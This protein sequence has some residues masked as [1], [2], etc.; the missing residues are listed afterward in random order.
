MPRSL[1]HHQPLCT[2]TRQDVYQ[3]LSLL[4]S[5]CTNDTEPVVD[6][7]NAIRKARRVVCWP[8]G[9]A[10]F[11]CVSLWHFDGSV[12][13]TLTQYRSLLLLSRLVL[14]LRLS[15]SLSPLSTLSLSFLFLSLTPQVLLGANM[16][17]PEFFLKDGVLMI[18]YRYENIH[19]SNFAFRDW[20]I[21]TD[22]VAHF[23]EPL[24]IDDNEMHDPE[25]NLAYLEAVLELFASVCVCVCVCVCLCVCVCV[26]VCV[27]YIR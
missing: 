7:Q 3:Y 17:L 18:K 6:A 14:A 10:V 5:L 16:V 23:V 27:A 24:A 22:S 21:R 26:C 25:S 1:C 4:S 19:K 11:G 12:K 9:L 20:E 8:L 2:L 15:L 13:V